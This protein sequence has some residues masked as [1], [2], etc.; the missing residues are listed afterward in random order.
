L[1]TDIL[2][3]IIHKR[4]PSPQK[5]LANVVLRN[6]EGWVDSQRFPGCAVVLHNGRS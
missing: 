4:H 6:I 5:L 2:G 3:K 1:T